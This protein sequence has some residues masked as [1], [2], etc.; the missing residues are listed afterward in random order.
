MTTKL[1]NLW[2]MA[3]GPVRERGWRET[4]RSVR[5]VL[6]ERKLARAAPF[7]EPFGTDTERSV[8]IADLDATGADVPALWRYWPTSRASFDAIMRDVDVPYERT[9]FVDLGS[10]K[11]RVLLMAA[12][13]PFRSIIGVELSPALHRIAG[14]NVR[15]WRTATGGAAA[16]ELEC[17]DARDWEPPSGETLIYLF[18]PFPVETMRAVLDRLAGSLAAGPRPA[19]H[20]AYLNPLHHRLIVGSGA[21]ALAHWGRATQKGAFDWAIYRSSATPLR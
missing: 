13:Y 10:G 21:F 19:I 7:D 4:A 12:E 20:I 11:G 16:I 6:Q 2:R 18:Q 9:A 17:M 5:S 15:R 3:A 14:D 1:R 8:T